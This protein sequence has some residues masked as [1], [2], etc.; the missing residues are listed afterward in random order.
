MSPMNKDESSKL[1]S[2]RRERAM[3]ITSIQRIVNSDNDNPNGSLIASYGEQLA[4]V[5]N[6]IN[7]LQ[8]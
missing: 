7:D 2:L 1:E 4:S 3:L 5:T 6:E 8:N